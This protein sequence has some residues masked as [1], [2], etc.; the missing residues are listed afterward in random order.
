MKKNLLLLIAIFCAT[1]LFAQWTLVNNGL[2]TFPPTTLGNYGDTLVLGSFGG[3]IFKTGDNGQNWIDITG[4]LGNKFVNTIETAWN[5]PGWLF[6]G[7]T[8]GPFFSMDQATYENCTSTGLTNTD[9]TFFSGGEDQISDDFMI[10]TN[11]GGMFS[12]G[13]YNGPWTPFNTGLTGDGLIIN[14]FY[15]YDDNNV[16]F[17]AMASENGVYVATDVN[18]TWVAK[19]SGLTGDALSVQGITGLG[20]A[21]LIATKAGLFMSFD[22]CETWSPLIPNEVLK[23]VT[24]VQSVLSSTGFF[25]FTYGDNG[26]YSED[27]MTWN[28]IDMGGVPAGA[29][30]TCMSANSTHMFIGIETVKKEST[31]ATGGVYNKPISQ[32][33]GMTEN[34][35]QTSGYRIGQN[36]PNPFSHTAQIAYSLEKRAMV[37]IRVSDLQGREIQSHVNSM[38][39][40]GNYTLSLDAGNLNN[41][42]YYYTLLINGR[43][44]ETKRMVIA[45]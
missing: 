23:G 12:S 5:G 41:G 25:M 35:H 39:E 21:I 26:F 31:I 19:S 30:I 40:K 38:Q 22:V 17:F 9:V 45:K 24:I 18:P 27:F 37:S 10:G 1:S 6:V 42:I 28:P 32:V 2:S 4:D 8:G 29:K 33:V 36:F 15:H 34:S 14:D 11:G 20:T 3:G 44:V 13:D 43:Q 7:T 16:N